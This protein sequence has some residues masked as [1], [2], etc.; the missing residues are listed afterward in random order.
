MFV[1]CAFGDASADAGSS[2]DGSS[3]SGIFVF[4]MHGGN[5]CDYVVVV[6]A[7]AATA[8]AEIQVQPVSHQKKKKTNAKH[9]QHSKGFSA[10]QTVGKLPRLLQ[11]QPQP[12]APPLAHTHGIYCSIL[13]IHDSNYRHKIKGAMPQILY[14]YYLFTISISIP[15]SF[16]SHSPYPFT[17]R[18]PF[19]IQ[20]Q[21]T[22]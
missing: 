6:A 10:K 5:F 20:F 19:P 7:A 15:I 3:G 21:F 22:L 17:F 16:H 18:F 2:G 14:F 8:V 11:A 1:A 13:Y 4:R 9:K 12:H